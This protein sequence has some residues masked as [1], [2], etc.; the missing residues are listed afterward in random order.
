MLADAG[1]AVW[2]VDHLRCTAPERL[3]P[4]LPSGVEQM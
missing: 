1:A 4:F 2:L 3:L